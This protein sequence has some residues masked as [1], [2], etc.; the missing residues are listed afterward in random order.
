[1]TPS[2]QESPRVAA[3]TLIKKCPKV[4][5]SVYW[6]AP[7]DE[8][9]NELVDLAK[10]AGEELSKADLLAALVRNAPIDGRE[11]GELVRAYRSSR[12]CDFNPSGE[13][14][15]VILLR[16]RRPGRRGV[17]RRA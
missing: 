13:P 8:R 2:Q 17:P 11:L 16:E 9:L 5:S 7:V 3:D 6:P 15:S 4:Q 10:E 12:A 1:M 14:D